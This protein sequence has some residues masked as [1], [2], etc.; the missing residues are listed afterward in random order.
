M[1]LFNLILIALFFTIL[2]YGYRLFRGLRPDL[3]FVIIGF[4]V[5]LTIFLTIPT[6]GKSRA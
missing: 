1:K 5:Y 4:L 2:D 3:Y 6:P